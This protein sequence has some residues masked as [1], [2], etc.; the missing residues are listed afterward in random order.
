MGFFQR[1]KIE[2]IKQ[3][4]ITT[5]K[6]MSDELSGCRIIRDADFESSVFLFFLALYRFHSDPIINDLQKE[7]S[8]LVS[9]HCKSIEQSKLIESRLD[10]YTKIS[11]GEMPPRGFWLLSEPKEG[12]FSVAKICCMTAFGDVLVSPDCVNDYSACPFP[13]IDIFE[14]TK[15]VSIFTGKVW[16]SYSSYLIGIGLK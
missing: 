9:Q 5:Q 7:L 6:T 12:S 8:L 11:I 4:F 2:R 3:G 1:K 15:F 14:L 10:L 13:I 16:D